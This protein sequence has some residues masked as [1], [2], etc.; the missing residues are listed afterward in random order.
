MAAAA[1]QRLLTV[2]INQ[3]S[4]PPQHM[5]TTN[6]HTP[7]S[8]SSEARKLAKREAKRLFQRLSDGGLERKV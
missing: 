4:L 2:K 1:L 8:L 7:F 3:I 6:M 5:A